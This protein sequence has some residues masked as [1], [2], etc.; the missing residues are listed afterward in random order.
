MNKFLNFM[1]AVIVVG[2]VSCT[3]SSNEPKTDLAKEMGARKL[4]KEAVAL[5]R[6]NKIKEAS[7]VAKKLE[8]EFAMTKAYQEGK[9]NLARMGLSDG[10][11]MGTSVTATRLVELQNSLLSFKKETG[12]WPGKGQMKAHVDAWNNDLYWAFGDKKNNYDL[13]IVS[14]GLD[15][16]PGTGDELMIVWSEKKMDGRKDKGTGD[17]VGGDDIVA[18]KGITKGGAPEVMT[19]DELLTSEMSSGTQKENLLSLQDLSK[20]AEGSKSSGVQGDGEMVLSLDEIKD[21][22]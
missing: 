4:L 11:D 6:Q 19:L 12:E 15:G 3:G 10:D 14:S 2:L 22:L 17:I 16:V 5:V 21:K 7:A 13:L 1:L 20:A 9:V 18:K 8:T